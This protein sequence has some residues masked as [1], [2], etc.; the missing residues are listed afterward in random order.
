MGILILKIT[1]GL[2]LGGGLGAGLGYVGKCSTGACPLTATPWRG[3]VFGGLLGLAVAMA[4]GPTSGARSVAERDRGPASGGTAANAAEPADADKPAPKPPA[5]D[6]AVDARPR[7]IASDADFKEA[8]ED[9][10]GLVFVDFYA[11]WCGWCKKLAPIVD[12]LAADYDGKVT[13]V[14]VD[15][16]ALKDLSARYKVEGLPTMIVFKGGQPAETIVGYRE[17]AELKEILDKLL[18]DGKK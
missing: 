11:D 8:V 4:M 15:T 5:G 12:K 16:D 2:G 6:K 13:F 10:K 18:A 14:K 17:K 3:A 7:K 9:A 1:L